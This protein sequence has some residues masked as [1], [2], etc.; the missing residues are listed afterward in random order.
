MCSMIFSI[1]SMFRFY[2]SFPR[3]CMALATSFC[4]LIKSSASPRLFFS[5][6]KIILFLFLM[7]FLGLLTSFWILISVVLF[8]CLRSTKLKLKNNLKRNE[9]CKVWS[10]KQVLWKIWW[11][12]SI[13]EVFTNYL[14]EWRITALY[15]MPSTLEQNSMDERQNIDLMDMIIAWWTCVT[16]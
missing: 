3:L 7:I 8:I 16:C 14:Q 15:A 12:S 13:H 4:N 10:C 6:E 1:V 9:D 5:A 11:K 2:L